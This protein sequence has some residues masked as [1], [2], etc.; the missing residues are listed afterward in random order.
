MKAELKCEINP[1][2][3]NYRIDKNNG[4]LFMI[5][6]LQRKI[7]EFLKKVKT[8]TCIDLTLRKVRGF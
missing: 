8:S 6:I 5:I 1:E 7:R 2:T 3:L 4:A